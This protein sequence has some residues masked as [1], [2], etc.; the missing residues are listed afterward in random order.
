MQCPPCS[1]QLRHPTA[2]PRVSPKVFPHTT[3][4]VRKA[5]GTSR[6]VSPLD[7]SVLRS[8]SGPRT[9]R[10]GRRVAR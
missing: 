4:H 8:G 5:A 9:D 7:R 6:A 2:R 10:R 3:R 1:L